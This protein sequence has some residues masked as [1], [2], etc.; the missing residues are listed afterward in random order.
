MFLSV[1][2]IFFQVCLQAYT[3]VP[4]HSDILLFNWSTDGPLH[5]KGW[6]KRWPTY[7]IQTAALYTAIEAT[8]PVVLSKFQRRKLFTSGMPFVR[9]FYRVSR[10][11]G[12]LL[13][14]IAT[15]RDYRFRFR[16]KKKPR[17]FLVSFTFNLVDVKRIRE[18]TKRNAYSRCT[19]IQ[20][21]NCER[22][23]WRTWLENLKSVKSF[24]HN[25]N[26][27]FM[28]LSR[29][30]LR[31]CHV[32]SSVCYSFFC[33]SRDDLFDDWNEYNF[34]I[35]EGKQIYNNWSTEKFHINLKFEADRST[36]SG[37]MLS[38]EAIS[39]ECLET[40]K[41][42]IVAESWQSYCG[43]VSPLEISEHLV[44]FASTREKSAQINIIM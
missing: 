34:Y 27:T 17:S 33:V 3:D 28:H 7:I 31:W 6:E 40:F 41:H 2:L 37:L 24:L 4:Q 21:N 22:S 25:R 11:V 23:T 32:E 39:S 14:W 1:R 5:L 13:P 16:P 18:T 30:R 42:L 10:V 36:S 44:Q 43:E 20:K 19:Q 35:E 9:N 38:D 12:T 15:G 26:K 29:K 8:S